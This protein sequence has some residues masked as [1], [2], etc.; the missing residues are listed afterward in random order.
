MSFDVPSWLAT[1][2]VWRIGSLWYCWLHT[3]MLIEESKNGRRATSGVGVIA[4]SAGGV[5]SNCVVFDVFRCF[6]VYGDTGSDVN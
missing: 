3:T 2:E 4:V 1:P 6:V 5:W